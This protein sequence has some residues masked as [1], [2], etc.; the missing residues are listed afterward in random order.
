[1]V[2][3]HWQRYLTQVDNSGHS[4]CPVI[5]RL[6]DNFLYR[7]IVPTPESPAATEMKGGIHFQ[8]LSSD[9]QQFPA[10]ASRRLRG[11]AGWWDTGRSNILGIQGYLH[12]PVCFGLPLINTLRNVFTKFE[13]AG[14]R[15][16]C[17]V[18]RIVQLRLKK[19]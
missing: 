15:E 8:P 2:V 18:Q 11:F 3:P 16:Y 14:C 17:Y 9:Q 13:W 4:Q 10:E 5:R 19:L 12:E 6:R 7:S 1:M